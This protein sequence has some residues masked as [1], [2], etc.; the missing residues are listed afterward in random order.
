MEYLILKRFDQS[1]STFKGLKSIST[2]SSSS[3]SDYHW[4]MNLTIAAF[5]LRMS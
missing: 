3:E 4:N 5:G 1:L 2:P